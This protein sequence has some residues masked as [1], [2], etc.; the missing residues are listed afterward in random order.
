VSGGSDGKMV[1]KV[2]SFAVE[3]EN[4]KIVCWLKTGTVG[5]FY[6]DDEPAAC[7]SIDSLRAIIEFYNRLRGG[8]D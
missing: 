8:E 3:G 5:I 1:E 4:Y 7:L 6:A 2:I